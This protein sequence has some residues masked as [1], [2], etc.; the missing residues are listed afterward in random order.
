MRILAF[1]SG[2]DRTM[3][4]VA[5]GRLEFL[6]EEEKDSRR[7][8]SA[9]SLAGFLHNLERLPDLPDVLAVSSRRGFENGDHGIGAG[10]LTTG[11]AFG[12]PLKWF[13]S[14][15]EKAHLF[16]SYA[17]S[18]FAVG[19]PCYALVWE[20]HIGAFYRIDENMGIQRFSTVLAGP[21]RRYGY[22]Y[23]LADTSPEPIGGREEDGLRAEQALALA[24]F[25]RRAA[26]SPAER[27]LLDRLL[28]PRIETTEQL[29]DQLGSDK[30]RLLPGSP[31]IGCGVRTQ[32]FKDLARKFSDELFQRFYDF[33]AEH[34]T[35]KLP[36]LVAGGGALNGGWNT[37]WRD[38]GLFA[39]VFVPPCASDGG[40]A[41]GTAAEAQYA[42]TGR[43]KI[44]WSVYAGEEFVEDWPSFLDWEESP[45]N[46]ETAAAWLAHGQVIAW[47]Q[48]RHEIGPRALGNRALLAAPFACATAVELN[49]I[50]EREDYRP[51]ASV[52]LREDA[53]RHFEGP[54]DSPHGMYFQRVKDP[55]LAAVT[56]VDGSARAQTVTPEENPRLHALLRAFKA[57]TGTGVLCNTSLSF[58]GRGF[59]NRMTHLVRFVAV[60]GIGVAVVND[61]MFVQPSLRCERAGLAP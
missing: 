28:D 6:I 54:P 41:I 27:A 15:H 60:R 12:R 26:A 11:G 16:G 46:L 22:L 21:G 43:A 4:S 30:G 32:E 2:H 44:E 8:N 37:R 48:G 39:E 18:P 45:L 33:A 38:S 14:T 36:L 49:R 29:D 10:T 51:I 55:R 5:D 61:R 24:G 59:I 52:C 17:L 42:L 56:H 7:R 57:A 40:N 50:K 31:F 13:H 1:K 3:A 53:H 20:R 34:L 25:G 35:E 23:Y 9:V 58:K 19:R 47:V